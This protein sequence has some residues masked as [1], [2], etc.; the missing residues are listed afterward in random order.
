MP[1]DAGA[2]SRAAVSAGG[3]RAA[4]N[5]ADMWGVVA[6]GVDGVGVAAARGVPGDGREGAGAGAEVM[7][8]R[9]VDNCRLCCPECG[10]DL[11][12]LDVVDVL[13]EEQVGREEKGREASRVP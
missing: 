2:G 12:K 5:M 11:L 1:E 6:G 4:S 10:F 7:E 9:D 13:A 8:V 3:K